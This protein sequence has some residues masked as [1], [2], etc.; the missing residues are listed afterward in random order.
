MRQALR[1]ICVVAV[2]ISLVALVGC[3]G[4]RHSPPV[5]TGQVTV[6]V[7]WPEPSEGD[8]DT[9]LIPERSESVLV[10]ILDGS[11]PVGEQLLVRPKEPPWATQASFDSVPFGGAAGASAG[12]SERRRQRHPPGGQLSGP[13]DNRT[14]A[15]CRCL[16]RTGDSW[17][18]RRCDGL[19]S[20]WQPGAG[21]KTYPLGSF[22]TGASW[23]GAPDMAGNWRERCRDWYGATYYRSAP[24][25]DPPGPS[26]GTYKVL[27]GAALSIRPC[28]HLQ[29][30]PHFRRRP[31]TALT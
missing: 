5:A 18:G 27:P 19:G 6:Q 23:C 13:G 3:H 26:S 31:D 21:G 1:I 7:I 25:E 11:T 16:R 15:V 9:Q 17:A 29:R 12:V 2:G 24:S 14:P 30:A 8:V 22:S 20:G 28:N 4:G 10:E